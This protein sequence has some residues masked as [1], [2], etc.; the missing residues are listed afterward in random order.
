MNQRNNA[1][2]Q[3]SKLSNEQLLGIRLKDLGLRLEGST[4]EKRILKLYNELEQKQLLF[5]PHIWISEEWFTPDDIPGFAVPFYLVHPR[6]IKLEKEQMF[7][8]EGEDK[9]ECLSILRHETGHAISHAYKLYNR[10]S[11]KK[12]FGD[13]KK[14]YPL[15]YVPDIGSRNYVTHLNAWYAQAH[16]LEDF[17]ET[18]AV[19]L[20]PKSNWQKKYKNWSALEKLNYMEELMLEIKEQEPVVS[21]RQEYAPVSRLRKTLDEYYQKKKKFY[22]ASWSESLDTELQKIFKGN[23]NNDSPPASAIISKMRK[24]LRRTI[25]SVLDIPQYTVDQIILQMIRRTS[26]LKLFAGKDKDNEVRLIVVLTS[27][28]INTMQTGYYRIPL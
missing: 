10:K 2:K 25:S 15:W 1:N 6:L 18:F 20:N 28:I 14:P 23:I 13:F 3:L 9:N 7:E 22:S 24:N 8:A 21:G 27:Q 19:W 12:I 11:W 16:P 4:L 5:K 26:Q 17:A